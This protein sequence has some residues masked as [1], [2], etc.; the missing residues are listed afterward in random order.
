MKNLMFILVMFIVFI[1]K[2][3][4][5]ENTVEYITQGSDTT[6]IKSFMLS[7]EVLELGCSQT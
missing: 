5:S 1:S 6:V 3:I 7:S 2:N 4:K